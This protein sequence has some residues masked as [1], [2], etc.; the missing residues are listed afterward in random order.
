MDDKQAERLVVAA[1][2]IAES[3]KSIDDRLHAEGED[4]ASH[5]GGV[6]LRLE[7]IYQEL[8]RR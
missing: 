6:W 2:S 3:L 8:T 1:E 7:S 5:V 4:L